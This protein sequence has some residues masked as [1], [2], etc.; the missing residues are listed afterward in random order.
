MQPR[1]Q[2]LLAARSLVVRGDRCVGGASQPR[3]AVTLTLLIQMRNS[4]VAGEGGRGDQLLRGRG[5]AYE[6]EP[7]GCR[8]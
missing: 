1:R 3:E 7:R 5:S 6:G 4:V 8:R 2:S